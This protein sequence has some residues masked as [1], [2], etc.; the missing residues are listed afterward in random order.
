[1]SIVVPSASYA[2]H[3]ED[4]VAALT[5][6]LEEIDR[7]SQT[8][9]GEHLV[10]HPL[11]VDV[12]YTKFYNELEAYRTFIND[13]KLAQSIGAAVHFDSLLIG[14][15]TLKDVQALADRRF[16][17]EL[18][19]SDPVTVWSFSYLNM[20]WCLTLGEMILPILH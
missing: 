9:H 3:L 13:Q 18:S 8:G 12:A 10:D 14:D 17:L 5:L 6:Q 16:A 19:N 11:Y 4:E 15:L 20:G 1:M 7:F 2:G